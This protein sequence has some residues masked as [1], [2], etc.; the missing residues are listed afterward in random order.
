MDNKK[1]FFVA[2][3]VQYNDNFYYLCLKKKSYLT[4]LFFF[5]L[6]PLN[7]HVQYFLLTVFFS[8]IEKKLKW[9]R[10][11]WFLWK[12]IKLK[13]ISDFFLVS[14]GLFRFVIELYA[15]LMSHLIWGIKNLVIYHSF[16]GPKRFL[17]RRS[18]SFR[19]IHEDLINYSKVFLW[20]EIDL[21]EVIHQNSL[22]NFNLLSELKWKFHGNVFREF[23]WNIFTSNYVGFWRWIGFPINFIN[24]NAVLMARELLVSYY[25]GKL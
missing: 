17:N 3:N 24:F 19:P 9:E 11:G 13:S 14:D 23:L 16:H 25:R 22:Q 21:W 4:L 15:D 5:M 18:F 6:I 20:I 8:F 10:T 12:I 1:I 7:C 2:F